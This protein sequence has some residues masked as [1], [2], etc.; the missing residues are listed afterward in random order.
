[1][2]NQYW[3]MVGLLALMVAGVCVVPAWVS[4][5]EE[6][7]RRG[8]QAMASA[9]RTWGDRLDG[10]PTLAY[11]NSVADDGISHFP[12]MPADC[13]DLRVEQLSPEFQAE[14]NGFMSPDGETGRTAPTTGPVSGVYSKLRLDT[15]EMFHE[16]CRTTDYSSRSTGRPSGGG[17]RSGSPASPAGGS[18]SSAGG[19][20]A[21]GAR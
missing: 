12:A 21:S 2:P 14:I 1:M 4:A 3:R 8:F 7:C 6:A 19:A 17:G 13:N 16:K 11:C 10:E 9:K 20:T 5:S 15:S 18:G